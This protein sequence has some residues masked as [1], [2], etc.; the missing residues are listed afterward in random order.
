MTEDEL[1]AGLDFG[2]KCSAQWAPGWVCPR[3]AEFIALSHSH[4]PEMQGVVFCRP[5][6]RQAMIRAHRWDIVRLPEPCPMCRIPIRTIADLL[7]NVER[8]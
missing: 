6:L 1:L 5:C 7:C 4:Q 3:P 8:L 2:A